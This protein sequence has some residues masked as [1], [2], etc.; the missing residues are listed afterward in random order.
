MVFRTVL[1]PKKA[2][3]K[4]A[5]L[6][7]EFEVEKIINKGQTLSFSGKSEGQTHVR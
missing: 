5:E 1:M 3:L 6:R 2:V 4:N 7:R